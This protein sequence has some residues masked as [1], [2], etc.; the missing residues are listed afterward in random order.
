MNGILNIY[1]AGSG[2]APFIGQIEINDIM[3]TR[4]DVNVEDNKPV[5][6]FDT[7]S[8]KK[9]CNISDVETIVILDVSASMGSAVNKIITTYLPNALEKLGYGSDDTVKIITFS[10]QSK[11]MNLN[12]S[13]MRM[14]INSY[15]GATYMTP[16]IYNL[17]NVISY[18]KHSQFRILS[19][20]DGALHDQREAVTSSASLAEV[21]KKSNYVISSS[22]IRLF[23]S[24]SQPDTRGLS[25]VLQFNTENDSTL[26]D[27]NMAEFGY[28]DN[29]VSEIISNTIKDNLG[30]LRR[31]SINNSSHEHILLQT[32]WS[33]TSEHLNLTK[34]VNT[35]WL[36][37]IP[38]DGDKITLTMN[39]DNEQH[40]VDIQIVHKDKLGF[41][42]YN[43]ILKD[44][45]TYF[46][47]KLR[48]LKVINTPQAQNEIGS[49][50]HYFEELEKNFTMNEPEAID[51]LNNKGLQAR[52]KFFRDLISK[53]N[54]SVSIK[55]SEIA[56]DNK[57][58]ML[59]SAQQATY[60]RNI[61]TSSNSKQLAKRALKTGLNFDDIVRKE[62][63]KMAQHI[64]ELNNIDDSTHYTSFYSQETTLGGIRAVCQ[65]VDNYNTIEHVSALDILK[66]INIVGIPCVA[67]IGEYPD[68]KTYHIKELLLGTCVSMSDVIM[69]KEFGDTLIDVFTS[70]EI[71]NTIPFYDDDRIQQFLMKYAPTL[72]E[73]VASL[74]VR[75]II[76][77]VPHTYKYLIVSGLYNLTRTIS[78][79]KQG[80]SEINVDILSKFIT[81]YKTAVNGIFDYVIDIINEQTQYEKDNHLSYY[82]SNNGVT[83]MISPLINIIQREVDEVDGKDKAKYIPNILR[84]LFSFETHQVMR[85]MYRSDSDG[86]IKR[87]QVL[88]N[89]LGINYDKYA[90][91]VPP[92]FETNDNPQFHTDTHLDVDLYNELINKVYWLNNI[93][94]I[95]QYIKNTLTSTEKEI[96]EMNDITDELVAQ[97][98]NIDF[99]LRT[100]K[101]YCIVQ[102]F[103]FNTKASRVEERTSGEYDSINN[104][105]RMKTQD[106]G[107][108]EAMDK[109]IRDYIKK[110]YYDE[111]KSRL[112][113]KGKDEHRTLV[114]E[115][116]NKMTNTNCINEFKNLFK[117]GLTRNHVSVVISD[118]NKLGFVEL[119]DSLFNS[120]TFV[121]LRVEKL[122]ILIL[123]VDKDD[124]VI[125]NKGNILRK[126]LNVLAEQFNK[127]GLIDEWNKLYE[128]YKTKNI[129]VYRDS[130]L[131]NRHS[132]FNGKS[133]FW[134]Y[135]YKNL[136]EYFSNITQ[137]E[138]DQY[139]EVHWECCGL[140]HG[141]VVKP[142]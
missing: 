13:Q 72:L 98:L 46:M 55:M 10:N 59:N 24:S 3:P 14:S 65:L 102:S 49:I 138:K 20:S 132:H 77:N 58:S 31:L 108:F 127:L 128:I 16:A 22:A 35:F 60:L 66:L 123:G 125:W 12:L 44:K 27:I 48:V 118:V 90:T 69:V 129:H 33:T 45:V 57:V 73:Y 112:T 19:I 9:S 74:G 32:P 15:E 115:L 80:R 40:E 124:I 120:D 86:Y 82:I 97:K 67:Q 79:S 11:I 131:P 107:S 104:R 113:Q 76:V 21:L 85:K 139:A 103:L 119:K 62:V 47:K 42:S 8:I 61:S 6:Y 122:R 29:V 50:V 95:P 117:E 92:F 135:G 137:D 141:K 87:K 37:N 4:S 63:K 28:S 53:K 34:G 133:S 134:A 81:T 89:L 88:D 93:V 109:M 75:R 114:L 106:C 100:F 30:S 70:K 7:G 38:M 116:I 142:C 99:D 43:S 78:D 140:W 110:Q 18:S 1:P 25:S 101:F 52:L 105:G 54:L 91:P 71:I 51:L 130:D 121:P 2:Q 39:I 126:S 136:R 26:V 68:P 84:A 94:M 64:T 96:L 17:R 83:N 56:N 5:N 23:T 41:N 36:K 111:Y